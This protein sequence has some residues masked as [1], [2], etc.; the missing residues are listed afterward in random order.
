[1]PVLEYRLYSVI[2]SVSTLTRH[3]NMLIHLHTMTLRPGTVTNTEYRLL[4][5][6][7]HIILLP[8]LWQ[9]SL[10]RRAV[11][12]R[13]TISCPGSCV[14]IRRYAGLDWTTDCSIT[15]PSQSLIHTSLHSNTPHCI[16][17]PQLPQR[18][19]AWHLVISKNIQVTPVTT[20][21]QQEKALH[22]TLLGYK[23][24][25]RFLRCLR[26][27]RFTASRCREMVEMVGILI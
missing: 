16:I 2:I 1:M 13:S 25:F 19:P 21:L 12:G 8:P 20:I 26:F 18:H 10:L 6:S 7:Y 5:S 14:R 11:H 4:S 3:T 15:T 17:L 22:L 9:G 24:I 23:F 27:R